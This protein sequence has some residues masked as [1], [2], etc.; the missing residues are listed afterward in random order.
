MA[1]TRESSSLGS[2]EGFL[3]LR[4]LYIRL[5]RSHDSNWDVPHTLIQHSLN[6]HETQNRWIRRIWIVD[7]AFTG[8]DIWTGL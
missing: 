5:T 7:M 8:D 3:I 6:T 4:C 2:P 1:Q